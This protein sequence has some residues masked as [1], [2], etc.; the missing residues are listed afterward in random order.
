[1]K[2]AFIAYIV[3]NE[4]ITDNRNVVLNNSLSVLLP[5]FERLSLS[6]LKWLSNVTKNTFRSITKLALNTDDLGKLAINYRKANNLW[7]NG[8]V[9]V[10]EYLDS[11]GNIKTLVQSTVVGNGRHAERLAI[12]ALEAQ[13]IPLKNVKKIYS[14]LELCE[15]ESG[16]LGSGGCKKMVLEKIGE[17]VEIR[18]SYPY[19][20]K[21]T[22]AGAK[23]IRQTSIDQRAI[24]FNKF[25]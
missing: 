11:S 24:D 17:N 18:Y 22:D 5:E 19:P 21:G 3:A 4:V 7:H 14:E 25:K 13:N 16:G 8:N 2:S 20:G 10:F 6:K 12:E 1:M 23:V 15:L 9:V